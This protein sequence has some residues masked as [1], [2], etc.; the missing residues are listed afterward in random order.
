MDNESCMLIKQKRYKHFQICTMMS[1]TDIYDN[2]KLPKE[3][4]CYHCHFVY[5]IPIILH[6]QCL[7]PSGY[8]L[9]FASESKMMVTMK[10]PI[11]GGHGNVIVN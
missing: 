1:I 5:H 4:N 3:V 11:T 7:I 9:E 2:S 10:E 8:A 6:V